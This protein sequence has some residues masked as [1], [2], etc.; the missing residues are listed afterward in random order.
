MSFHAGGYIDLQSG[1]QPVSVQHTCVNRYLDLYAVSHSCAGFL[2]LMSEFSDD[3]REV[4]H[5]SK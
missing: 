1:G 4:L 2:R 5:T 3:R